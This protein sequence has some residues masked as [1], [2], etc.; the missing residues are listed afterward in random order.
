MPMLM[1]IGWAGAEYGPGAREFLTTAVAGL[2]AETALSGCLAALPKRAGEREWLFSFLSSVRQVASIRTGVLASASILSTGDLS[3]CDAVG[4]DEVVILQDTSDSAAAIESVRAY[5]KE[6]PA[7]TMGIRVWLDEA[8]GGGF[9]AQV[10]AWKHG[11]QLT[12]IDLSPFPIQVTGH[13]GTARKTDARPL[14][15]EWLRSALTVTPDGM[16][17]PCPAHIA[18]NGNGNGHANLAH[19]AADVLT[20]HAAWVN[21]AGSSPVCHSCHRLAR[22][23]GADGIGSATE[24]RPGVPQCAPDALQ[25]HDLVGC[26]ANS[27]TSPE[28]EEAVAQFVERIRTLG[29]EGRS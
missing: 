10:C 4:L 24:A 9:Q 27:L 25:Y 15:C 7:T 6:R 12:G 19:T 26:D 5:Q 17:M 1:I 2:C 29:S 22:F 18:K 16:V 21:T 8:I 23:V 3:A 14:A 13:N 11:T 20:R 28:R